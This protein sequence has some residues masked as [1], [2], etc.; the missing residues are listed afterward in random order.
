[1]LTHIF[2]D[3]F[4]AL[5]A[6]FSSRIGERHDRSYQLIADQ[7]A[8]LTYAFRAAVKPESLGIGLYFSYSGVTIKF[9]QN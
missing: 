7:G 9:V 4:G 2:F 8:T 5:V 1:M 3:F 6:Y